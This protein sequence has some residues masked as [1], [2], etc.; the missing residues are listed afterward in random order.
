MERD[1]RGISSKRWTDVR[2]C[3]HDHGAPTNGRG[4]NCAAVKVTG[5][6]VHDRNWERQFTAATSAVVAGYIT[7]TAPIA[8]Y[9]SLGITYTNLSPCYSFS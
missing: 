5:P 9:R 2:D 7:G 8:V 4:L 3:D 1:S 6:S